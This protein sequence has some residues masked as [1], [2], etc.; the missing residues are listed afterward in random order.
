MMW[1]EASEISGLPSVVD[2]ESL[3]KLWLGGKNYKA[4]NALTTA[5]I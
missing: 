3:G 2:F 4:F 1:R 5:V